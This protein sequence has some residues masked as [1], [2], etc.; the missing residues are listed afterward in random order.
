MAY[1][2]FFSNCANETF[3]L[4]MTE[5]D[6]IG[7]D[8]TDESDF[9]DIAVTGFNLTENESFTAIAGSAHKYNITCMITDQNIKEDDKHYSTDMFVYGP[10]KQVK[11]WGSKHNANQQKIPIVFQR[12]IYFGW[13][14]LTK[15][16]CS[17]KKY[18]SRQNAYL[19]CSKSLTVNV[20]ENPVKIQY[21]T[22]PNVKAEETSVKSM[23][24]NIVKTLLNSTRNYQDPKDYS[25]DQ[26]K[27]D[28]VLLKSKS[29][30]QKTFFMNNAE[31]SFQSFFHFT[32]AFFII[33]VV[34]V[35]IIGITCIFIYLKYHRY[36]KIL[37][38]P[39]NM[40]I[41][42]CQTSTNTLN[43]LNYKRCSRFIDEKMDFDQV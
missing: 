43:S 29:E 36:A 28:V 32:T 42:D 22:L 10:S 16:V 40:I 4:T 30:I 31:K 12:Y 37:S 18:N 9:C 8:V 27:T 38:E 5:Y 1:C 11:A 23:S 26:N 41:K 34:T 14:G 15:L 2:I 39:N 7:N 19:E 25:T 6:D 21:A 20:I 3:K 24:R 33:F 13:N 17:V 35:S